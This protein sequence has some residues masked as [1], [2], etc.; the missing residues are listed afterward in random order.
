MITVD[1]YIEEHIHDVTKEEAQRGINHLIQ[2]LK[3]LG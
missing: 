3:T 1:E 2:R